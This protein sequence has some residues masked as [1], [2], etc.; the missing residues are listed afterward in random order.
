[1]EYTAMTT[2]EPSIEKIGLR[3]GHFDEFGQFR[4]V[5]KNGTTDWLLIYTI[6]GNGHFFH[7]KHSL[8]TS[9]GDII[10][11]PPGTSHNYG[12]T[13]P[14]SHWEP[15]WIHF[16]PKSTWIPLLNWPEYPSGLRHLRLND[17]NRKNVLQSMVDMNRYFHGIQKRKELFAL[18]CLEKALLWCD[19][20][21]PLMNLKSIDERVERAIHYVT[22]HLSEHLS[23]EIISQKVGLSASRLSHLCKE[24]LDKG[25]SQIIEEIRM[26]RAKDLVDLTSKPIGE[27]ATLTGFTDPFY[28]SKRFKKQFGDSPRDFRK[29]K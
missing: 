29:K 3:A 8:T 25:L 13:T 6:S 1:M 12:L 21:N 5:R 10:L 7:P 11:L 28:F 16:L 15:I 2:I 20:Q 9:H 4:T 14:D 17:R 24:Y 26:E 19:S 27:I 18:N 23:I 22:D